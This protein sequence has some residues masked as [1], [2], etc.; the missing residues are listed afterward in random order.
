MLSYPFTFQ[1]TPISQTIPNFPQ[2]LAYPALLYLNI[3]YLK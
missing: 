3:V 2:G 1:L